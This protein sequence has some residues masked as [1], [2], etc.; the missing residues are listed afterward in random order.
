M[1]NYQPSRVSYAIF[2]NTVREFCT[3]RTEKY[4]QN[5]GFPMISKVWHCCT[6][7]WFSHTYKVVENLIFCEHFSVRKVQTSRTVLP[8]ICLIL[9]NSIFF[10]LPNR[11][12]FIYVFFIF[13]TISRILKT[14]FFVFWTQKCRN[15]KSIKFANFLNIIYP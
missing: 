2:C 11:K 14:K 5:S 1:G 9:K 8:K 15:L 10:H 13:S 4:S 6:L 3:Y 12:L 7:S